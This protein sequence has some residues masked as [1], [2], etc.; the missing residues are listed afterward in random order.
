MKKLLTMLVLLAVATSAGALTVGNSGQLI[1]T[2]FAGDY[3]SNYDARGIPLSMID[4]DIDL[5]NAFWA[6]INNALAER[7]DLRFQNTYYIADDAG[8][9]LRL[10]E[11]GEVFVTFLHEGA[12]Y[13]NSFG[14]FTYQDGQA[15]LTKEQVAETIVFPNS[16]FHNSGGS[17]RGM[18]SGDTINLGLFPAGTNIGFVI[19]SNG[20]GGSG[21]VKSYQDRDWIFYT[22][23]NLNAENDPGLRPHTVLLYDEA[24]ESV[25]LGM[26]DILRTSG[27]CDHDFNDLIF[28]VYANPPTAIETETL[29]EVP[30]STDADNDGVPDNNDD[31]PNDPERAITTTYP[32]A[33]GWGTL[34]FEDNWPDE[35]DYDLNDLVLRYRYTQTLD[36]SNRIKDIEATF[37]ITARGA[38]FSNGFGLHLPGVAASLV[39][40]A[41][42]SINGSPETPVAVEAGQSEASFVVIDNAQPHSPVPPGFQFH[43]TEP[44]SPR[45][46]GSSFTLSLTLSAA[47]PKSVIG[48]PPY[49]PFLFR[50][51][52]R[53]L[54]VHL[55]DHPP[56]DLAD[57]SRFG[58]SDDDSN[59]AAGRTYKTAAN[60]PWALDIPS[61]WEHPSEN[62]Q[63][64]FAYP[65]LG[66]WAQSAGA[67]NT[68]WY[69]VNK[70]RGFIYE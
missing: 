53:G 56:T 12:G 41:A 28:T 44:G 34:A 16:S 60:L 32:S 45:Q 54:E 20:Y 39:E 26:E 50:S 48:L 19:V 37:E 30:A 31:F 6:T 13:K 66:P 63:V 11:A 5:N 59:V 17:S 64:I 18:R 69:L 70:D 29:V 68:N 57:L 62:S 25:I 35:G 8:S 46:T 7:V 40:S 52:D 4:T 9:N 33:N 27:S 36:A 24:S 10:D 43:N 1:W 55:P 38:T 65:D 23:Q 3:A 22:L 14:Y 2:Y 61:D 42:L 67:S 58:T 49:N 47:R 15:P 51:W 21:G